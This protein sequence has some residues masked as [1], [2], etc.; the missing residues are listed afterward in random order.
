MQ[1]CNLER[2]FHAPDPQTFWRHGTCPARTPRCCPL[3]PPYWGLAG[4]PRCCAAREA[5][6]GF[7]EPGSVAEWCTK[8]NKNQPFISVFLCSGSSGTN[9]AR[10]GAR[11]S[12]SV[13]SWLRDR[14]GFTGY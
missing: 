10:A 1:S 6:L 4:R 13:G 5:A 7:E 3:G 2:S 9:A 12:N 14:E 11:K 8:A